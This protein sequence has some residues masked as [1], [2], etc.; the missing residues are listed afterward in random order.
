MSS[1]LHQRLLAAA[2]LD[3]ADAQ[4]LVARAL[5][6]KQAARGG[7]ASNALRGKHIAV[8]C[9]NPESVSARD[10]DAAARTLGARVSRIEA[11]ADWMRDDDTP[12]TA[13]LLTR[14]YDAIDCEEVP[15]DVALRLQQR[16]D[17]PVFDGLARADHPL[18]QLLPLLS[19]QAAG[20]GTPTDAADRRLLVQ[21]V[22]VESLV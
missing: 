16:V 8:L 3:R 4:M 11:V 21:A 6:L 1:T 15:H 19:T 5:T 12:E 9:A 22:L 13:R 17:V 2:A 14:L 7:S 20:A 10:F 18:T